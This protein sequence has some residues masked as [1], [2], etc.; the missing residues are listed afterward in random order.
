MGCVSPVLGGASRDRSCA[1]QMGLRLLPFTAGEALGVRRE[2]RLGLSGL[3]PAQS[4]ICSPV[5]GPALVAGVTEQT[6]RAPP[7]GTGRAA[8]DLGLFSFPMLLFH[9]SL[10]PPCLYCS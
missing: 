1:T 5:A 3:R 4:P 8:N 10:L 9:L 6:P 7:S 2:D